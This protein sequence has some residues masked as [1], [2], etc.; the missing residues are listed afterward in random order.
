MA[1]PL[2]NRVFVKSSIA[3]RFIQNSGLVSKKRA[4]R[5][6][7]SAAVRREKERRSRHDS[8]S[9][10]L[11]SSDRQDTRISISDDFPVGNVVIALVQIKAEPFLINIFGLQR[12]RECSVW[13]PIQPGIDL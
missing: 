9:Q 6:A 10:V 12:C 11:A 1:S 4:R 5:N 7:V 13:S 8:E 2:S 3:C